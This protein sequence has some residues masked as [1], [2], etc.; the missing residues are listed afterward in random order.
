MLYSDVHESVPASTR[1][2]KGLKRLHGQASSLNSDADEAVSSATRSSRPGPAT[3]NEGFLWAE[4]FA[5]ALKRN[6]YGIDF[7]E[8]LCAKWE[9]GLVLP[10][11]YS[12]CGQFETAAGMIRQVIERSGRLGQDWQLH[13]ATAV[14]PH[15]RRT[16]QAHSPHVPSCRFG[17]MLDRM[18][19]TVATQ[20]DDMLAKVGSSAVTPA[21]KQAACEEATRII[22]GR[23][24]DMH[25]Q[26]KLPSDIRAKCH[27]HDRMCRVV[28]RRRSGQ[29]A[30]KLF[31]HA[32]GVSR[33][34]W[35]SRGRQRG[36]AGPTDRVFTQWLIERR[37]AEEDLILVEC[38]RR[39]Q[40]AL[41]QK[42]FC[43]LWHVLA[44]VQP[45]PP[46]LCL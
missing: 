9:S 17:D 5:E 32:L 23:L 15:C 41:L 29:D 46:R 24:K 21:E 26:G 16:L 36:F 3:V 37:V 42:V 1:R 44:C 4:R 13:R 38:T 11:D 8:P 20:L 35:S 43:R 25:E 6:D 12:G 27:Q 34:D 18:Q 30:G 39:F 28:R 2:G 14:L 45:Q 10:S 19:P 33:V 7:W 31:I 22:V 40:P